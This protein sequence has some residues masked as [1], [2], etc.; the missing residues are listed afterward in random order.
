MR[1]HPRV[2]SMVGAY[3]TPAHACPIPSRHCTLHSRLPTAP[4]C[5]EARVRCTRRK[6][7]SVTEWHCMSVMQLAPVISALTHKH[8]MSGSSAPPPL[9]GIS[10]AVRLAS[11]LGPLLHLDSCTLRLP[12]EG[13]LV[14]LAAALTMCRPQDT[15]PVADAASATA[16]KCALRGE[17]WIERRNKVQ[18]A[19]SLAAQG[20][21]AH[22]RC[23]LRTAQAGNRNASPACGQ[24][25]QLQPLRSFQGPCD[26]G[27]ST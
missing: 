26:A 12:G 17:L 13:L 5:Q 27:P 1:M 24:T 21:Q 7:N 14:Q 15:P 16:S 22:T 19:T 20:S 23:G 25:V 10:K 9:P 4:L 8:V 3:G 2:C 6:T 11:R 18:L